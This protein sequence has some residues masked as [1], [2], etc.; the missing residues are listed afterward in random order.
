MKTFNK[1][2]LIA[3]ALAFASLSANAQIPPGCYFGHEPISDIDYVFVGP[4]PTTYNGTYTQSTTDHVIW[5][6]NAL[7]G[8]KIKVTYATSFNAFF[9]YYRSNDGTINVG[10]VDP[11]DMTHVCGK[12]GYNELTG[13]HAGSADFVVPAG[14]SGQ[15][16]LMLDAFACESGSYSVTIEIIPANTCGLS[17]TMTTKGPKYDEF[18]ENGAGDL[19]MYYPGISAT[20]T[21]QVHVTGGVPPYTAS[22][23]ATHGQVT[24][25]GT[26][27]ERT[28]WIENWR[29]GLIYP[30]EPSKMNVLVTDANGCE[31]SACLEIGYVN[32]TCNPPGGPA[33]TE[34]W[35]LQVYRESDNMQYCIEGTD[36]ARALLATGGHEL[37]MAPSGPTKTALA[38]SEFNLTV[39]PNPANEF[40]VL[41]F[42]LDENSHT[43][44]NI[45][46]LNGRIVRTIETTL[47]AGNCE[48]LLDLSYLPN[49]V[50]FVQV[51][52]TKTSMVEKMQV[53]K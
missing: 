7:E 40:A 49:G 37:G 51:L 14:K 46:D 47:A 26:A 18:S 6:I 16:A 13:P 30:M 12:G 43:T 4:G 52:T 48:Y 2:I 31:A 17:V 32:Y 41:R 50:Y 28:G 45:L 23:S 39:S 35:Y 29:G 15:F 1:I 5:V 42:N 27:S 8:Q 9:W 22:W 34:T 36:S 44:I 20:K 25:W 10:D 19:M 33:W 3:V 21:F 24:Q 53:V 38:Y 11:T